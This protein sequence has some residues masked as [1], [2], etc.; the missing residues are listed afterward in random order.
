MNY[1]RYFIPDSII[2]ATIVTSKR[3]NILINNIN[4]IRN[5][6]LYAKQKYD[7]EIIAICVLHDHIHILFKPEDIN[8]YPIIIRNFKSYFS[9]NIDISKITDYCETTNN[10]KHKAKDIWQQRYYEHNIR[11]EE[12][13]NKHIDY[14]HYNSMKHYNIAPKDWEYSSFKKFV[15]NGFY[16]PDWCNF[17]DKHKINNMNFE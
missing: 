8:T 12:D 15:K 10:I 6:F 9:R 17:N 1:R 7:F 14:I 16:E 4:I 3:R 5:A 13:L 2:F 11:N